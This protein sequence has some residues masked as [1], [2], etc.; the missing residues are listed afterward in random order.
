MQWRDPGS[1]TVRHVCHVDGTRVALFSEKNISV[2]PT[3]LQAVKICGIY[4]LYGL[5]SVVCQTPPVS[6]LKTL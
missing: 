3:A 2:N 1:I 5:M 4:E 6:F